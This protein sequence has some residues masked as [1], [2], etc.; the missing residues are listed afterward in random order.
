M[1]TWGY[2]IPLAVVIAIVVYATPPL[3]SAAVV[4]VGWRWR[5]SRQAVSA[6]RPS[7]F[8]NT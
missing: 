6:I 8:A 7:R 4:D 1:T 5:R 2:F 3:R